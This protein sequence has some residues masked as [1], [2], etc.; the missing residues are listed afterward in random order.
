[1]LPQR[2]RIIVRLPSRIYPGDRVE[3]LFELT[4]KRQ[5]LLEHLDIFFSGFEAIWNY[6]NNYRSKNLLVQQSYRLGSKLTLE[7]G[8]NDFKCSF[9]LPPD[10]PPSYQNQR[11]Q[12]QYEIEVHAALSWW[13]DAKDSFI[14][15]IK[16]PPQNLTGRAQLAATAH[17]FQ[18]REPYIEASLSSNI[19]SVGGYCIGAVSLGNV[20]LNRY[21]KISV[22]LVGLQSTTPFQP[23]DIEEVLHRYTELPVNI[24]EEGKALPFRFQIPPD[25]SPSFVGRWGKLQ[26]CFEVRA[27]ISRKS[28]CVLRIPITL[29]PQALNSE[30]TTVPV[31]PTVGVA[32]VQNIWSQVAQRFSLQF[33]DEEISGQQAGCQISIIREPRPNG[34]YLV[35]RLT[36]SS[37]H[38]Q[39]Q[40]QPLSGLGRLFAQSITFQIPRWDQRYRVQ[41]REEEQ[42]RA[43]VEPLILNLDQ[44][45]S[46][47]TTDTFLIVEKRDSGQNEEQ[48]RQFIQQLLSI[49]KLIKESR[50]N[51]P[52]PAL[53]RE[54]L[55]DWRQL[56]HQLS[57][58]LETSRMAVIGAFDGIPCEVI[59]H[60]PVEANP[61]YTELLV[62]TQTP[63]RFRQ[64]IELQAITANSLPPDALEILFQ[65][66]KEA[67]FLTLDAEAMSLTFPTY[68]LNPLFLRAELET[69]LQL[70]MFLN[71]GSGPYR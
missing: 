13:L 4:S 44:F 71:A 38:L 25:L 24:P 36:F 43:F 70:S 28:D 60:W 2:P 48:L 69:L 16:S 62:R 63:Q 50:C 12:V 9:N 22:G 32:R 23:E 66:S 55:D 10:L 26:W 65:L 41:A 45:D 37:L 51:I 56:A 53:L 68:L 40:I 64:V 11:Y 61:L 15:T 67:Q 27:N 17:A 49:T 59:T 29:L 19:C 8:K 7:K 39:L 42:A 52:A 34:F 47:H 21:Q 58:V 20:A 5:Q 14:A 54:G 31:P 1:M 30:A 57:T 35:G 3:A 33:K 6:K 46:L 18:G